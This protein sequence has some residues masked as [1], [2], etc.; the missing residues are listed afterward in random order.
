MFR[1]AALL[2]RSFACPAARDGEFGAR[3]RREARAQ[4]T[5]STIYEART[6]EDGRDSATSTGGLWGWCVNPGSRVGVM[7]TARCRCRPK[8]A[9]KILTCDG[10]TPRTQ[11]TI[12]PR[13]RKLFIF[14]DL[15]FPDGRCKGFNMF[16]N[17][18]NPSS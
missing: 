13:F 16:R 2:G 7:I 14:S 17:Y 6:E 18:Q 12:F 5:L 8:H 9:C 3:C 15:L 1:V 10:A 11:G 4:V